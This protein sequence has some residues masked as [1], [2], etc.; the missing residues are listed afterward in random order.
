MNAKTFLLAIVLSCVLSDITQAREQL[1]WVP[2][3]EIREGLRR[4]V[5]DF[6][7]RLHSAETSGLAEQA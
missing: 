5:D 4:T 7:Q 1:G 2:K 6:R 3:T